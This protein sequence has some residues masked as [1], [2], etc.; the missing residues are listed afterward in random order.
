VTVRRNREENFLRAIYL[1]FP[2]LIC[3]KKLTSEC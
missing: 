3:K 2:T 1:G